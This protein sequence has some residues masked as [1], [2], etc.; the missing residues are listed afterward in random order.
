MVAEKVNFEEAVKI[1]MSVGYTVAE[2]N[3]IKNEETLKDVMLEEGYRE[4]HNCW[5]WVDDINPDL[6][7]R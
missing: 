2:I 1:L 4:G 5:V 3:C 6:D 7:M